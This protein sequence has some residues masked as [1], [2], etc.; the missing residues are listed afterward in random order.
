MKRDRKL[1]ICMNDAEFEALEQLAE[2]YSVEGQKATKSFLVRY[3]L[4][5][6]P[7]QRHFSFFKIEQRFKVRASNTAL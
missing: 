7:Q 3:A 1:L 2:K 4:Q 5:L 6:L